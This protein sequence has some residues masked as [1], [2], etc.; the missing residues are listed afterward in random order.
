MHYMSQ[1]RFHSS[2]QQR[3]PPT[4]TGPR[5]NQNLNSD[6]VIKM[7]FVRMGPQ[8]DGI[9]L[10]LAFV[11]EPGFDHVRGEDLAAQQKRLITFKAATRLRH[12]SASLLHHLRL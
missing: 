9:D 5:P 6:V 3:P 12:R 11:F 8:R 1:A 7:E 10:L 2:R 4:A